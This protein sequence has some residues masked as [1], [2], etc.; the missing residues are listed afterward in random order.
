VYLPKVKNTKL[1]APLSWLYGLGVWWRNKMFDWGQ[2]KSTSFEDIVP[3]ICVG[4]LAVGGT[5]KTPHTEYLVDLLHRHGYGPIAVLS[6]G[7][8]RHSDGYQVVMPREGKGTDKKITANLL[9]DESYQLYRKFPYLIVAVDTN[10]V[11]GINQLLKL[12]VPPSVIILDDAMQHRYVKPGLTI[13]L[14][15][16]SRIMYKDM[17]LPAG[18]LREPMSNVTRAELIVVTKCPRALRSEE[19]TEIVANIPTRI[20]QP[21]LYSAYEYG[22]LVNL[23]TLEECDIDHST[24]VIV[25]A[26]IADP[27]VMEEYVHTHYRLLDIINFGDHHHFSDK[28]IQTIQARLDDV[29]GRGYV[30]ND[31]GS[32]AVIITT[33]K[34]AARLVNHPA[35]GEELRKRIYY[36]PTEV[37]FLKNHTEKFE[38]IVLDYVKKPRAGVVKGSNLTIGK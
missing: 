21:I 1:L 18:R 26:G 10:R 33:E 37:Y 38:K 7:Y 3:V 35:V 9:G 13:C 2:K 5:G 28:D 29:N 19:E 4:N 30:S 20:D 23:E 32:K 22:K 31:S 14:S 36:L 6:R 24:E 12:D 16:Y 11:H 15:S 8:K 34:D 25:V 27:K 17:L